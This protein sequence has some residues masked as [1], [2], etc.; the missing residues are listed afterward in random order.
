MGYLRI[1][2]HDLS[3]DELYSWVGGLI[4]LQR[5]DKLRK[6][7][8]H[9]HLKLILK[10]VEKRKIEN[11]DKQH[12]DWWNILNWLHHYENIHEAI[13]RKAS[14]FIKNVEEDTR[15]YEKENQ[16][17]FQ[18]QVHD[19]PEEKEKP[20]K[21]TRD[22]AKG[23]KHHSTLYLYRKEFELY[24]EKNKYKSKPSIPWQHHV[25]EK[26]ADFLSRHGLHYIDEKGN[27]AKDHELQASEKTD[28]NSPET[29]NEQ[30][31]TIDK[32][33]TPVEQKAP[34]SNQNTDKE[35]AKAILEFLNKNPDY[36]DEFISIVKEGMTELA[37][38]RFN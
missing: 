11:E 24:D 8:L 37:L 4:T 2:G 32:K 28:Q 15:L 25:K 10:D 18:G 13:E 29:I 7:K 17:Y 1:D 33:K 26:F 30:Q 16:A 36:M 27:A 38:E 31:E 6:A 9:P 20:K 14:D 5:N 35:L 21:E 22:T 23:N 3:V 34:S 19:N 12:H